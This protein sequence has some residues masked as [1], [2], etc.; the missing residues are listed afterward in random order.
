MPVLQKTGM[1][2]TGFSGTEVFQWTLFYLNIEYIE[3]K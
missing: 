3:V 1:Y 2:S